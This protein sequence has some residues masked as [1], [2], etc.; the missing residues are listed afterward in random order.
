MKTQFLFI[1]IGLLAALGL[2]GCFTS[3]KPLFTDDQA[4]APY[5][6]IAFAKHGDTDQKTQLVR[7]GK[8]YV[9]KTEDGTMTMRFMPVGDGLY[10]AESTAEQEGKTVRLYG[11]VRLDQAQHLAMTYKTVAHEGD[12]GPGLPA[13]Q[14]GK[15]DTICIE[16]VAAYVALAKAAIAAGGKPDMTYDVTIE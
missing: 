1:F 2:A 15:T 7:T 12:I 14:K 5:A 4:V 10:L 16:D 3:T 11:V 8:G 13:C 6:K 9:A